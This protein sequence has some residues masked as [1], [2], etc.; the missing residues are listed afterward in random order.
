MDYE[1]ADER[2]CW[3]TG[4]TFKGLDDLFLEST[5]GDSPPVSRLKVLTVH[6]IGAHKPGYSRRLLDSLVTE[7]GLTSMSELVK[8]IPLA[9]PDYPGDLGIL[10]IYRY[11][12][13]DRSRE[14]LFYELTWDSIVEE[15]IR[16]IDYDSGQEAAA[17]R[18]P[19]LLA[20]GFGWS[21]GFG[22]GWRRVLAGCTT[23]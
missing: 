5:D 7:L 19:R 9:H 18:A 20:M 13:G 14:V 16:I 15:Q 8:T 1:V 21:R 10:S 17:K 23:G 22:S 4:R 6:G 3:I 12:N 11:L 2:R